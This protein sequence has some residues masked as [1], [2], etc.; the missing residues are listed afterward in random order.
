MRPLRSWTSAQASRRRLRRALTLP[1]EDNAAQPDDPEPAPVVTGG[2]EWPKPEKLDQE[3]LNIARAICP[4]NKPASMKLTGFKPAKHKPRH[5]ELWQAL[6]ER[7]PSARPK[8]WDVTK[9]VEE[10][11]ALPVKEAEAPPQVLPD[12]TLS[13]PPAMA[14]PAAGALIAAPSSKEDGKKLRLGEQSL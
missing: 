6:M 11:C 13:T 7:K 2:E 3:K 1:A 10:L 12:G 4:T 5:I 14:V 8:N 9:L